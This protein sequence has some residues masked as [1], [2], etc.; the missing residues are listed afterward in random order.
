MHYKFITY[1]KNVFGHI[2]IKLFAFSGKLDMELSAIFLN[3][4]EIPVN[5]VYRSCT[6]L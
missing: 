1:L 2:I 5:R 6:P 4:E 3:K